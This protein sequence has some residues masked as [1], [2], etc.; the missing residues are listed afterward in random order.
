[1]A[2]ITETQINGLWNDFIPGMIKYRSSGTVVCVTT[3]S[4]D[5]ESNTKKIKFSNSVG[6]FSIDTYHPIIIRE[7]I[8]NV[9]RAELALRSELFCQ[10]HEYN[11]NSL[12]FK[13]IDQIIEFFKSMA[14]AEYMTTMK[15]I[16]ENIKQ[17]NTKIVERTG[18]IKIKKNGQITI[19]DNDYKQED[20]AKKHR[21][22]PPY[23]MSIVK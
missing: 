9:V 15:K 17:K 11:D 2:D 22:F 7:Q 18:V 3:N 23:E 12:Q 20:G 4:F 1:M 10:Y 5:I 19:Y 8:Y 16:I 21:T 6:T 14:N 13:G